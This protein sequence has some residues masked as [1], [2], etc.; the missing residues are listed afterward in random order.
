MTN[1]QLFHN[2]QMG[3]EYWAQYDLWCMNHQEFCNHYTDELIRI[4]EWARYCKYQNESDFYD[5]AS[6]YN[7]LADYECE[8]WWRNDYYC[9]QE[10]MD[11]AELTAVFKAT[12]KKGE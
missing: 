8:L 6:D 4:A 1:E 5:I 7:M 11:D 12:L 3:K 10:L 9:F 2:Q